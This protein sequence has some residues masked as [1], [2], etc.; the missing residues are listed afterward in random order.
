M[1]VVARLREAIGHLRID[2]ATLAAWRAALGREWAQVGRAGVS[3]LLSAT[4]AAGVGG[5]GAGSDGHVPEPTTSATVAAAQVQP[6]AANSI[7]KPDIPQTVADYFGSEANARAAYRKATKAYMAAQMDSEMLS[8]DRADATPNSFKIRTAL[9]ATAKSKFDKRITKA[10][11]GDQQA[12]QDVS[13]LTLFDAL[14]ANAASGTEFRRG[15]PS[16]TVQRRIEAL[17]I[18]D[19]SGGRPKVTFIY[20]GALRITEHDQRLLSP[21]AVKTTL[22]LTKGGEIDAWA[23]DWKAVDPGEQTPDRW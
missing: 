21:Y 4:V 12:Y 23:S 2:R 22:W 8:L 19:G 20:R 7:P 11:D 16:T 6:Y 9:S 17:R 15:V 5:C 18:A 10:A 13:A 3:M 14:D 1:A